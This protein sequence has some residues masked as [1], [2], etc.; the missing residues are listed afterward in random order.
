[1]SF[2]FCPQR[3]K[4]MFLFPLQIHR[5]LH[6]T[7]TFVN[8]AKSL[9][10]LVTQ[11]ERK[12]HAWN[13][14]AHF[15]RWL[16]AFEPLAVKN[17][18]RISNAVRNFIIKIINIQWQRNSQLSFGFAV[19]F[20]SDFSLS[21]SPITH[22]PPSRV[23]CVF[24]VRKTTFTTNA[25]IMSALNISKCAVATPVTIHGIL[26]RLKVVDGITRIETRYCCNLRISKN[27]VTFEC[28][29]AVLRD[30]INGRWFSANLKDS[31]VVL[32][33]ITLREQQQSTWTEKTCRYQYPFK[34]HN[35]LP[36]IHTERN[37]VS[38]E[39]M[40][41]ATWYAEDLWNKRKKKSCRNTWFWLGLGRIRKDSPDDDIHFPLNQNNRISGGKKAVGKV[42][43]TVS[44]R[45]LVRNGDYNHIGAG[46]I[47]TDRSL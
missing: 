2:A 5:Q 11:S 17:V 36:F 12:I 24:G 34:C 33:P 40:H 29:T 25:T 41:F 46:S 7:K 14:F 9:C 16:T 23:R 3:T 27:N 35:E 22:F 15:R 47:L 37:R 19:V 10:Q 21:F 39:A 28:Q 20:I 8:T 30:K 26:I 13:A 6:R 32:I 44:L 31:W 43:Y 45:L 1:M 42:P 38:N 18:T 4:M